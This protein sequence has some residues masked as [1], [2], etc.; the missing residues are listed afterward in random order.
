[1]NER[2]KDRK[3]RDGKRGGRH[4]VEVEKKKRQGNEEKRIG[5]KHLDEQSIKK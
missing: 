4:R 1:M 2:K 3:D 5:E